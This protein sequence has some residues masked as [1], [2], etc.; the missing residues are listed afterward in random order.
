MRRE[1]TKTI[2]FSDFEFH[3]MR[4]GIDETANS[5]TVCEP[6]FDKRA[7]HA[8]MS[9]IIADAQVKAQLRF[10]S[11]QTQSDAQPEPQPTTSES[12]G[13]EAVAEAD[14][15]M[16]CRMSMDPDAYVRFLEYVQQ[17]LSGN[18]QLAFIGDDISMPSKDRTPIGEEA[19]SSLAREGGMESVN[20]V[21]GAFASFF[22]L[23]PAKSATTSGSPPS[24]S[25]EPSAVGSSRTK[26]R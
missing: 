6:G 23:V 19:W 8:K 20:R 5:I 1:T 18:R 22:S 13:E 26:K 21:L 4:S 2:T 16:V 11:S 10:A 14:F 25:S 17:Q 24:S 3:Y 12:D 15:L 9:A 7:V